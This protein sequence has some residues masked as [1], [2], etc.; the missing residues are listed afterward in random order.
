M[1]TINQISRIIIG[2]INVGAIFRIV[3]CNIMRNSDPQTDH[4]MRRRIRNILFF[5]AVADSIFG[6]SQLALNYWG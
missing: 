6:L 3:F 1:G 2:L 5:V 4:M